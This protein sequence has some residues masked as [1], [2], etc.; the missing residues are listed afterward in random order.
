M[1]TPIIL[2]RAVCLSVW[3]H[4]LCLHRAGGVAGGVCEQDIGSC[5]TVV[6]DALQYSLRGRWR[7]VSTDQ[8]RHRHRCVSWKTGSGGGP[9]AGLWG[10]CEGN[11]S[12]VR[13][14]PH[15]HAPFLGNSGKFPGP[16]RTARCVTLRSAVGGDG[17]AVCSLSTSEEIATG[18]G[19]NAGRP[20]TETEA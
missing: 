20:W 11:P 6:P 3:S 16:L 14:D 8:C 7:G 4:C 5:L 1:L 19:D 10:V 17:P 12:L 2:A 15:Q 18:P 13:R 9:A